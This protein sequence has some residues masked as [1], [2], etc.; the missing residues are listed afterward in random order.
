MCH[1][2]G[3]E[4]LRRRSSGGLLSVVAFLQPGLD[5][6]AN[7]WDQ[8]NYALAVLHCELFPLLQGTIARLLIRIL[9][10]YDFYDAVYLKYHS[11]RMK[12]VRT[13]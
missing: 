2:L 4:Y 3:N 12:M 13:M 1:L 7:L 9:Y 8:H 6:L 11:S 5:R 10:V